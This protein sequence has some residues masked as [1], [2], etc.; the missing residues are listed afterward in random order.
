MKSPVTKPP[1]ARNRTD[2]AEEPE[3]TQEDSV[4]SD[5]KDPVGEKMMEQLGRER[6]E[7]QGKEGKEA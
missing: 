6:R 7:E 3:I 2:E 1:P 4:P 5:G